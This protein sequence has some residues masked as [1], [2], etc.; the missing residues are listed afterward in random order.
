M[1]FNIGD[2]LH[3][4][5]DIEITGEQ[6]QNNGSYSYNTNTGVTFPAYAL[7]K[8]VCTAASV[9]PQDKPRFKAGDKAKVIGNTCCHASDI[10]DIVTLS[11]PCDEAAANWD[12]PAWLTKEHPHYYISER[13]ME[14]YA[15][16][17]KA[18]EAVKLYCVDELIDW[19]TRGKIYESIGGKI[20]VDTGA[21]YTD[22][23]M[24]AAGRLYPLVSR[25][26]KAG[27]WVYIAKS[28]Y[29]SAISDGAV[30]RVINANDHYIDVKGDIVTQP[31]DVDLWH[32]IHSDYLTLDGYDGRYE[33]QEPK[34]YSGKVVCVESRD[35][36]TVGKVYEFKDGKVNDDEGDNRPMADY[37]AETLESWNEDDGRCHTKFIEYKGEAT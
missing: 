28:P 33:P 16:P 31:S 14:P 1:K 7:E 34:Y 22:E 8:L 25:P 30:L 21:N 10:G 18:P 36:F 13:D 20:N 37:R 2:K 32:V 6:S 11:E 29:S 19:L 35:A 24:R 3:I 27:E 9:K 17:A 26:A 23:Y 15:E 12:A 5:G 4:S